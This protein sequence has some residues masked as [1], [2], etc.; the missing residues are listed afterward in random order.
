MSDPTGTIAQPFDVLDR[1]KFSTKRA[2][3]EKIS[4]IVEQFEVQEVVVGLPLDAFGRMGDAA[5]RAT[6]FANELK[7]HINVPVVMH[8]ESFSSAEADSFLAETAGLNSKRRKQVI[9]KMAA[10]MILRSFLD[11]RSKQDD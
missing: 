2:L 7:E 8:D 1:R 3:I 10:A 9:D 5:Q 11:T 6:R 4:N